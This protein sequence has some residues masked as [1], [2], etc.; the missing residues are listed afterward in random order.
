MGSLVRSLNNYPGIAPE[1]GCT[2]MGPGKPPV[3][4]KPGGYGLA[5]PEPISVRITIIMDLSGF[6]CPQKIISYKK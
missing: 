6:Y 2:F 4:V 5:P 1:S 3:G